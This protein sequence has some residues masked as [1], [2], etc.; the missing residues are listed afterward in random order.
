MVHCSASRLMRPSKQQRGRRHRLADSAGLYARCNVGEGWAAAG[1]VRGQ[2]A[3]GGSGRRGCC[4]APRRPGAC[5][6]GPPACAPST[7]APAGP[8]AAGR[9]HL[10]RACSG[11]HFPQ[12]HWRLWE[13]AA[14]PGCP[15]AATAPCMQAKACSSEAAQIRGDGSTR[16]RPPA[17]SQGREDR[18][19]PAVG[20]SGAPR[21]A[22]A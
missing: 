15:E 22:R 9:Q 21:R 11:A 2:S 7:D 4:L 12:L 6:G 16:G 5:W 17:Q 1:M 19:S 3:C 13:P 14:D 8:P 20:R 18:C 10:S